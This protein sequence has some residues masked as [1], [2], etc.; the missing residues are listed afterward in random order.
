MEVECEVSPSNIIQ[1]KLIT[2]IKLSSNVSA[3][4]NDGNRKI[5]INGNNYGT[6][7]FICGSQTIVNI[8][9]CYNYFGMIRFYFMNVYL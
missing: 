8:S 6:I 1:Q 4:I 7:C 3:L 5:R 2:D 9:K